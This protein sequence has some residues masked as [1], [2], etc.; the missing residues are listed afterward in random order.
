MK[1][2]AGL[3][4]LAVVVALAAG[5][6]SGSGS[7]SGTAAKSA[8]PG[9][10]SA[11]TTS[12]TVGFDNPLAYTNNMAVLIAV[13]QGF[14]KK[15]GIDVKTIGFSGGSTA[16]RAVVAG[17]ADIQAGVGF[18]EVGATAKNLGLQ[19]FYTIARES[20]FA[21]YASTAA[22]VKSPADFAGKSLGISA[23][24][25]YS[26]YLARSTG[27]ALGMP[28]DSIKRVA[29]GTNTALFG[30]LERGTTGGT[31]NP[32]GLAGVIKGTTIVGTTK[33]LKIPTQYSS[34]IAKTSWLSSHAD[35]AKNFT[36][37]IAEA[38][39]WHN[40][41]K[42]AAIALAEKDLKLPPATAQASYTAAQQIFTTD[43]KVSTEGLQAMATAVPALG[44][45]TAAP[46]VAKMS[47][48]AYLPGS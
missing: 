8:A 10:G 20:D 17:S 29:L 45:G 19:I 23:F 16:S 21:L 11:K 25:S 43:G 14:F 6:G 38:I 33:S 4:P 7:G 31:W 35:L 12:V 18:D 26:D 40:A 36:A 15:R 41:N 46:S 28:S 47:T 13:D 39:T 22:G 44:L 27:P 37:A 1:L 42:T 2:K 9:S 3:L 24:G 32:A 34:L 30:A 5:C 48:D